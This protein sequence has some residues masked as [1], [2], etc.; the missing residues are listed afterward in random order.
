MQAVIVPA[1]EGSE[2]TVEWKLDLTAKEKEPAEPE[3]KKKK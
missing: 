3:K 2:E 1:F